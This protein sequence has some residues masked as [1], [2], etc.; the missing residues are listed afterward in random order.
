MTEV[1][2]SP[3]L[4]RAPMAATPMAFVQAI[5]RAYTA[6]SM[7][8]SRALE[9]AQITPA[10]ALNPAGRIT[11][12]QMEALSAAAMR[13]LDAQWPQYGLAAHKG[14]PTAAHLAA[15]EAH[16]VQA[17]HRR[18]FAPVRKLLEPRDD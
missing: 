1:P 16:G 7:D 11:S 10:D 8:A 17:F 13:E 4:S 12:Q 6:R 2:F 3:P 15:L 5:V 14:Y 18:S 9:L